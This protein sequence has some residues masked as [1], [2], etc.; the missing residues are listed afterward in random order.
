MKELVSAVIMYTFQY[1]FW[2][3]YSN[4]LQ[5]IQRLFTSMLDLAQQDIHCL[6]SESTSKAHFHEKNPSNHGSVNTM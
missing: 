2:C 4:Y 5:V 6:L 1:K 3:T